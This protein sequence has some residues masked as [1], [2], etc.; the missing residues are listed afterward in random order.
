MISCI[1]CLLIFVILTLYHYL[2]SSL[3]AKTK[4]TQ[5]SVSSQHQPLKVQ[6]LSRSEIVLRAPRRKIKCRSPIQMTTWK[7]MMKTVI[8]AYSQISENLIHLL[9]PLIS[10]L[11]V[12][13]KGIINLELILFLMTRTWQLL[14]SFSL[15]QS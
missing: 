8:L 5:K 3:W 11:V 2:S 9:S 14:S 7:L 15:L 13:Q 1:C 12:H 6:V 4:E 10:N